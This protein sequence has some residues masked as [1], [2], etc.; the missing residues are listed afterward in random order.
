MV[1]NKLLMG[2]AIAAAALASSPALAGHPYAGIEIG[3][4]AGRANDVDEHVRYTATQTP[5]TPVQPVP[6][7][8]EADDIFA[9]KYK[10]GLDIDVLGGYD[11]GFFR[12]EA[13]LGRKKLGIRKIDNDDGSEALIAS[14]NSTLNRPSASPDPGAPGLSALNL[15]D[16]GFDGSMRVYSALINGLVDLDVTKRFSVYGGGGVGKSWVSALGDHDSASWAWQ[17]IVGARYSIND[18]IDLGLKYRYFNSGIVTL[19]ADEM[20]YAGNPNRIPVT[21]GGTVDQTVNAFL[22]PEIEG[23]FRTR[24]VLASLIYNF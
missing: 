20:A 22:I 1:M 19:Q 24:S 10:K 17:W 16:F 6:E 8:G 14:L 9:A 21:G 18:R 12:V 2:G 4:A 7:D 11:F 15:D 5:A 13:E 3:G 23:E